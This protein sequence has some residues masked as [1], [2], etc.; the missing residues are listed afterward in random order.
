MKKLLVLICLLVCRAGHAQ[1]TLDTTSGNVIVK[2]KAGKTVKSLSIYAT[3]VAGKGKCNYIEYDPNSADY[4]AEPDTL[5]LDFANELTQVKAMLDAALNYKKKYDFYRFAV[6]LAPYHDLG[7]K[8]AEIF[9]A[10]PEWNDYIKKA[11]NMLVAD[12]LFDGNELVE[13][14]YDR[15]LA[16]QILDKS[17]FVQPLNDFFKPYGYRVSANGFP[18]EHQ[19]LLSHNELRSLGKPETLIIPIPNSYFTLTKIAGPNT[20]APKNKK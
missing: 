3:F 9:S 10:S 15:V 17:D 8:L 18:V 19:Q 16:G 12:T 14:K 20:T 4:G 13:L 5:Y 1:V 7:S 6:N 2:E 11:G